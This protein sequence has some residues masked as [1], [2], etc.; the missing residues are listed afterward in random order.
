MRRLYRYAWARRLVVQFGGLPRRAWLTL[1]HLGP[2]EFARRILTFPLRLARPSRGAGDPRIAASSAW[3][4]QHARPVTV[5]IPTYGDPSFVVDAVRSLRATTAPGAV[6]I[7]VADDAS[8]VKDVERLR[9]IEEIELVEGSETRGF[10]ANC[11]RGIGRLRPDEDLVL[12]NSDVIAHEGWLEALQHVAYSQ[13]RV[14][15]VGPKLLYADGAIQSAGSMRNTGAP[16]WFDHRYRFRAADHPPANVVGPC[17]AVTGAAMYV[18][19]E[20]LAA[21]GGRFD[22]AY[23]MAFEDA[24]WCLRAWDSGWRVLY[25]PFA[26]LTHLESKTRGKQQGERELASQRLFW[27]RW[28]GWLED[29]D[30]SADD[31]G[32]RIVYVTERIGPGTGLEQLQVLRNAG[33]HVELWACADDRPAG[34]DLGGMTV[35][36][37]GGSAAT[38]ERELEPLA[39]VKVTVGWRTAEQV[40]VASVRCGIAVYLVEDEQGAP[41]PDRAEI[42][43]TYRPEFRYLTIAVTGAQRLAQFHVTPTVAAP[44]QADV[45]DRFFRSLASEA[46]PDA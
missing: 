8:P 45:L 4:A 18:R 28:R 32:L 38:L 17:L 42:I 20:C 29:R 13:E 34:L 46:A 1:T 44:G 21:I 22:E 10:A 7:V 31:G 15:I 3:Y 23:G 9:R 14:G 41:G 6:R 25:C 37:F 35:R 12:L 33:H 11:N 19:R 26:T 39:A 5:V 16:E 27:E 36:T 2:R 24:D 40:W 43:D 30:V